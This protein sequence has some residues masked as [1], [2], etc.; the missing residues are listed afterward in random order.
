MW[1][2]ADPQLQVAIYEDLLPSYAEMQRGSTGLIEE[3]VDAG[4]PDRRMDRLPDLL[5]VLLADID[6]DRDARHAMKGVIPTLERICDELAAIPGT[7]DHADLHGGNVLVLGDAHRL[8]DWGD[9]QV[10]HPFGTLLITYQVDFVHR[11]V[12]GRPLPDSIDRRAASRRLR[13]AYL[14]AW[15]DTAPADELRAMFAN[16]LWVTHVC[17]AI[18]YTKL[19]AATASDAIEEWN[20]EIVDLLGDWYERRTLLGSDDMI[21]AVW[22]GPT[23]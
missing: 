13:D 2:T 23:R 5:R 18:D 20:R 16:A 17:R 21:D 11:R 19:R 15:A 6:I 12:D 14:E 22:S 4:V 9:A 7:I 3:W 8:V 1:D 10:A